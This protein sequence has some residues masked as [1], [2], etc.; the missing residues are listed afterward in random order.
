MAQVLDE[1]KL[2]RWSHLVRLRDASTCQVCLNKT[3]TGEL[4]AHHVRPKALYPDEAYDL[5]NGISICRKCHMPIV[6]STDDN[7]KRFVYMFRNVMRRKATVAFNESN[8]A[9]VA[10]S[11]TLPRSLPKKVQ[12]AK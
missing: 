4:E 2:D 3:K 11:A 1:R 8:Q 12:S 10:S 6:H 7:W 9:L 5:D